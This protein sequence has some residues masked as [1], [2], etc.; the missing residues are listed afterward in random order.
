M[1]I[2]G[3]GIAFAAVLLAMPAAGQETPTKTAT[4]GSNIFDRVWDS[5]TGSDQSA[6]TDANAKPAKPPKASNA[7]GGPATLD[8]QDADTTDKESY[9]PDAGDE[10]H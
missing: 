8:A 6:A 5:I 7:E 3:F 9:R 10:S 1:R 4:S 2:V